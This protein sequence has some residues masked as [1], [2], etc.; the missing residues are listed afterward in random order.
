MCVNAGP[1]LDVADGPDTGGRSPQLFVHLDVTGGIRTYAGGVETKRLRVR[2]AAGR[3]QQVRAFDD[4]GALGGL[5]PHR[6]LPAG[7]GIDAGNPRAHP[8]VD[9]VVPQDAQDG[10]G[11][12]RIFPGQDARAPL[13]HRYARAEPAKRLSEFDR[14]HAAAEDDE[15]L[16]HFVE[17]EDRRGIQRAYG[18]QPGNGGSRGTAAGVDDEP[19]GL[20]AARWL[21][22]SRHRDLVRGEE[23]RFASH[24]LEIRS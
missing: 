6:E 2:R 9:A 21:A 24:D 4:A 10:F 16:G 19:I 22:V 8:H 15:V 23:L 14:D 3:N 12:I 7:D 20:Q 11:D 5:N 17:V 13:Q 1:P 18:V